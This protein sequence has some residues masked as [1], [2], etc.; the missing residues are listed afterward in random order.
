MVV[1][2]VHLDFSKAFD[3][4]SHGIL[5]EK[6][7]AHVLDRTSEMAMFRVMVSS[8]VSSWCLSPRAKYLVLFNIC[9]D[10]LDEGLSAL[11]IFR[12]QVRWEH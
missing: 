10:D 11:S 9:I 7:G 1:D 5:L 12:D 3:F 2:F 4:L 8:A 6:L